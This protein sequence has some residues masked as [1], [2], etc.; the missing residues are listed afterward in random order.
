MNA[1]TDVHLYLWKLCLGNNREI[2]H[3]E[4]VVNTSELDSEYS[5]RNPINIRKLNRNK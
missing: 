1:V 4:S 3:S 5:Y 2:S